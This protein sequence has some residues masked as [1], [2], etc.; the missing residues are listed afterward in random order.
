MPVLWRSQLCRFSATIYTPLKRQHTC[1]CPSFRLISL[2][3]QLQF[4]GRDLRVLRGDF[5]Y[6]AAVGTLSAG[7]KTWSPHFAILRR[8]ALLFAPSW[9][10][11]RTQRDSL[12][13]LAV[14]CI[15]DSTRSRCR[16]FTF[17]ANALE[18]PSFLDRFARPP[19]FCGVRANPPCCR[20]LLYSHTNGDLLGGWYNFWFLRPCIMPA[21][22]SSR[23]RLFRSIS[24]YFP[25]DWVQNSW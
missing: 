6:T 20:V 4:R 15:L 21:I 18:T 1:C 16:C 17:P 8:D 9:S 7:Q 2:K 12:C 3:S 25:K 14:S 23:I 13:R 24:T 22:F 5:F 10:I 19:A 11:A